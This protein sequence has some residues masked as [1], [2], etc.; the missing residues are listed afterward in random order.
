MDQG[1]LNRKNFSKRKRESRGT[2]LL[3]RELSAAAPLGLSGS[4]WVGPPLWALVMLLV[5]LMPWACV[6]GS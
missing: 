2:Q 3:V 1:R 5:G 6:W 4:A